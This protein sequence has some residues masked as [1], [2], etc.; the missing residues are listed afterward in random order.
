[1]GSAFRGIFGFQRATPAST[2]KRETRPDAVGEILLAPSAPDL[3]NAAAPG[4]PSAN[5][6]ESATPLVTAR[7][8]LIIRQTRAAHG[9]IEEVI[10]RVQSG[11]GAA[12]GMAGLGGSGGF[13][14]GGGGF[15]GGFFS[16]RGAD[17]EMHQD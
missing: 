8:V 15:G 17:S 13:G 2:W 5:A 4:A 11:D 14:G 3:T 16:V 12:Q 1:M 10:R 9:E 6:K 7:A